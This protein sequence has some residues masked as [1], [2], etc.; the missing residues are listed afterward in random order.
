VVIFIICQQICKLWKRRQDAR[1]AAAASVWHK[2]V[3]SVNSRPVALSVICTFPTI[4]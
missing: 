3:W 4:P 2:K 1:L